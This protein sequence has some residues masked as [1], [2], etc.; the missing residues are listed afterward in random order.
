MAQG[1]FAAK[2]L[3][4]FP[5]VADIDRPGFFERDDV[6]AEQAGRR[7]EDGGVRGA[8]PVFGQLESG[9]K[10]LLEG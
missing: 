6:F 1:L 4:G 5:V 10:K 3:D 9:S 7:V 2:L 8:L